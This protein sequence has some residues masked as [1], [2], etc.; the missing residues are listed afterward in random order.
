MPYIT[1]SYKPARSHFDPE[2]DAEILKAAGR[3]PVKK[4]ILHPSTPEG[5]LESLVITKFAYTTARERTTLLAALSKVGDA[6]DM[7][8]Q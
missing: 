5:T 3:E 2:K 8:D 4:H 6:R 1:V 7:G